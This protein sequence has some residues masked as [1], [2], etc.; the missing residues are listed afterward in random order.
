[1]RCGPKCRGSIVRRLNLDQNRQA[2][3]AVVFS[4][5]KTKRAVKEAVHLAIQQYKK[6][7]LGNWELKSSNNDL[8]TD[9][10]KPRPKGPRVFQRT[11]HGSVKGKVSQEHV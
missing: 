2:L 4:Q 11:I 6:A 3:Q 5:E 10:R 8:C 7:R 9:R 1:M